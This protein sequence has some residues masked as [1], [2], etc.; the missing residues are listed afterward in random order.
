M[1]EVRTVSSTGGEKGVKPE[2]HHLIPVEALAEVGH[3][4]L[5]WAH[6]VADVRLGCVVQQ[7]PQGELA[8]DGVG[9]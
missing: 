7:C 3:V 5:E 4:H 9:E 8:V 6:H 1:T 2:Q